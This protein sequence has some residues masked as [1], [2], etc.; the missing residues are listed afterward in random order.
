M[1]VIIDWP[2]IVIMIFIPTFTSKINIIQE[3]C[4][5]LKRIIFC[6]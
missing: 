6:T 1:K 2:S 4:K 3:N 5:I